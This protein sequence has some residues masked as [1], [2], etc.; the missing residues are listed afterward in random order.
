M[1]E[2]FFNTSGACIPSDHYT[3]SVEPHFASFK[4]LIDNKRY[5]I[6]HAPRQTGKTTLMLRLM[7][8]LNE[9]GNYIALYVDVEGAQPL[10]NQVEAVNKVILSRFKSMAKITLPKEYQPS[11]D[12]FEVLAMEEGLQTFLSQW[13]LELPKPLVLLMDEVDSLIGDGLISVLRQLRSGYTNRPR[14]FPQAICLI[15][16]RELNGR[17]TS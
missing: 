11:E 16:L 15:G 17:R 10:R 6:L 12:C 13:C 9:A 8:N 4:K 7:E 1:M 2:K 3:V 14:A 5:F